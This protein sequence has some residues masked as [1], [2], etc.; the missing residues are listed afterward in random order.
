MGIFT[1]KPDASGDA[2]G[3]G[4]RGANGNTRDTTADAKHRAEVDSPHTDATRLSSHEPK[5]ARK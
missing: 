1:S 4:R 3:F 2:R 5:R